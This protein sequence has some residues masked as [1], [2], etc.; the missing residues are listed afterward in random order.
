MKSQTLNHSSWGIYVHLYTH[1]Q[2]GH[3]HI[4]RVPA[5][6]VLKT[7]HPRSFYCIL[8]QRKWGSGVSAD[9]PEAAHW[10]LPGLG[11]SSCASSQRARVSCTSPTTPSAGSAGGRPDL[12]QLQLGTCWSGHLTFLLKRLWKG[13]EHWLHGHQWIP[14]RRRGHNTEAVSKEVLSE[15]LNTMTAKAAVLPT[16]V[17]T[18]V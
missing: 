8:W 7:T 2:Q 17:E 13:P 1:T 12:S 9:S 3:T 18:G 16:I 11:F 6:S 4:S 15:P 14:A 5:S 10:Q